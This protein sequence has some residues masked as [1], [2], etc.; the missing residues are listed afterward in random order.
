LYHTDKKNSYLNSLHHWFSIHLVTPVYRASY[1]FN[2]FFSDIDKVKKLKTVKQMNHVLRVENTYLQKKIHTLVRYQDSYLNFKNSL[3]Y[4]HLEKG[5]FLI[6]E[7]ISPNYPGNYH[8]VLINR[9]YYDG[10]VK[11]APVLGI[12]G[13]IGQI[14]SVN[15]HYSH[16]MFLD[17]SD[18]VI[19][20]KS[21]ELSGQ[22]L[23]HGQGTNKPLVIKNSYGE[24]KYLSNKTYFLASGL[25]DRYP[26]NYP[27]AL[28]QSLT[29]RQNKSTL[30]LKP[31][32]QLNKGHFYVILLNNKPFSEKK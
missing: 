12:H 14:I 7:Q 26:E 10:V 17:D 29:H 31:L 6:T 8:R 15:K 16:L 30:Y 3:N 11:G 4:F 32:E 23:A 24:M 21:K 28:F 13:I 2:H 27:V 25:G 20:L 19:P 22:F 5:T 18:S 9:G 1:Q